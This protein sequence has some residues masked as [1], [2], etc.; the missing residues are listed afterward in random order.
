[1][2]IF[3][4]VLTYISLSKIQIS[5]GDHKNLPPLSV[6]ISARNEAENLAYNLPEIL[7]QDYPDF[8][9]IVVNDR[10]TDETKEI[11]RSLSERYSKLEILNVENP[12]RDSG[13]KNALTTGILSA[14]HEHLV[15][16]DADCRPSSKTWLLHFGKSFSAGNDLVIGFGLF[17]KNDGLVNVHYRLESIRIALRYLMS[18]VLFRPY[19][20][21]GRSLGYSKTLFN[22]VGG[23]SRHKQVLSGDDDLFVQSIPR[24]T[25]YEIVLGATTHSQAPRSYSDWITQKKRH[26]E[27]G[28]N[29]SLISLV[30]LSIIEISDVL[31]IAGL[32]II[33]WFGELSELAMILPLLFIRFSFYFISIL[34][35]QR[36]MHYESVSKKEM[37]LDPSLSLLNPLFSVASQLRRS[38]EWNRKE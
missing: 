4:S 11:L 34:K 6:I 23:F 18:A 22:R 35:F 19:M 32:L 21:V 25:N 24:E 17:D 7:D 29:Y 15:F 36:L 8:E 27:A 31:S 9:V 12:S 1:M 26:L 5:N 13:K 14:N 38:K 10:S 3:L 2:Q 30:A 16:T 37:F 33:M 20:A 28:K